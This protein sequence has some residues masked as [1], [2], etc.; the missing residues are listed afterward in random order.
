MNFFIQ[1]INFD[2]LRNLTFMWNKTTPLEGTSDYAIQVAA[3]RILS[4]LRKTD[5]RKTGTRKM[6]K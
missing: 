3:I 2:H 1:T 6:L 5:I 4:N